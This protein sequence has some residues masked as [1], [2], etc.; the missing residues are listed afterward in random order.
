M[1]FFYQNGY[2]CFTRDLKKIDKNNIFEKSQYQ[3]LF[4]A[5]FSE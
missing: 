3:A 4:H 2:G 1:F 5:T